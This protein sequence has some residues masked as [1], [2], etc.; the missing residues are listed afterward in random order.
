MCLFGVSPDLLRGIGR[1]GRKVLRIKDRSPK[2]PHLLFDLLQRELLLHWKKKG[3]TESLPELWQQEEPISN[4]RASCRQ[5]VGQSTKVVTV[6][7]RQQHCCFPLCIA[8]AAGEG[9]QHSM[10]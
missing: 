10:R 8:A 6:S 7:P 2:E 5:S 1:L 9:E 4:N 3:I